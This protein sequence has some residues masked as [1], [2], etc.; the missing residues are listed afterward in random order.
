[1][2]GEAVHAGSIRFYG[3]ELLVF[4]PSADVDCHGAPGPFDGDRSSADSRRFRAFGLVSDRAWIS[5]VAHSRV[6]LCPESRAVAQ[7]GDGRASDRCRDMPLAR[8]LV[9]ETSPQ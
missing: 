6:L 8:L 7:A 9:S 4:E 3:L 2:V 1:L 5:L